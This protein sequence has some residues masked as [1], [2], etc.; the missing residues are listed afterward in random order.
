MS[1]FRNLSEKEVEREFAKAFF[2]NKLLAV[3]WLFL[4]GDVREGMGE[5]RLFRIGMRFLAHTE[6]E[7]AARLLPLIPEYT[8]WDNLIGLI[9]DCPLTARIIEIVKSQLDADIKNM[10]AKK[11]ISLL[12]KWM[13]SI[14]ASSDEARATAK[15]LAS[16]FGMTAKQYRTTLSKLRAYLKL[17]E[18]DI[19]AGNWQSVDYAAVPS[20]A[21]LLYKNA[22]LKHDVTRRTQFLEKLK[23]GK[24]KI[25]ADVL[26]PHDI[27]YRYCGGERWCSEPKAYDETLEQL[28]KALPD[29]VKGD[30]TTIC[31]ADGS[32]SMTAPIGNTYIT[33]LNVAN[34]LAI[35]FAERCSGQFKDKFITFSER[36]QIVDLSHCDNLHDKI[37]VA[38]S[39][40]ECANTNIEAVFELILTTAVKHKMP[41]SEL[42]S[43][44]LILSDM[45]FD[46]CAESNS[47]IIYNFQG[48]PNVRLFDAIKAKYE[49]RGYKLPRLVFWNIASR[50]HT[51]PL[52]ENELG[53]ALVSGFG[54]VSLTMA[55]S[56]KLD[57][58]ECLLEM[59]NTP[60]YDK[61]EQAVNGN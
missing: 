50:T 58:L 41:Q 36:P 33:A 1:S 15:T 21:N 57:P 59:I 32:G 42:P 27:V 13:P 52:R 9:G 28:W 4:A 45:E 60:R 8:R 12:A 53:V 40:D 29:Y 55:L 44:V 2:E 51:I 19:S 30:G 34:G 56:G 43:T 10:A 49:K 46:A 7:L 6:P 39:Y 24:T 47:G 23:Q 37:G 25:N 5:R 61:V 31:V 22:F 3:K 14:N 18:V 16:A 11:P 20:K 54:P 48:T 17:V 35:Y 38:L 26:F